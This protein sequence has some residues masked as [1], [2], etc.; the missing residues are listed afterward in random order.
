M[1]NSQDPNIFC[2]QWS[3]CEKLTVKILIVVAAVTT[4]HTGVTGVTPH[5]EVVSSP[6]P[7]H[8]APSENWGGKNAPKGRGVEGLGTRLTQRL[9]GYGLRD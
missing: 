7:P 9:V 2:S 8:H 5:T 3:N 1:V 6:D 4:G